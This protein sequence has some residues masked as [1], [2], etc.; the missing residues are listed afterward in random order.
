MKEKSSGGGTEQDSTR[1]RESRQEPGAGRAERCGPNTH[2]N[3]E[4]HQKTRR[5]PRQMKL[6]SHGRGNGDFLS[7]LTNGSTK[8]VDHLTQAKWV[9]I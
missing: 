9:D 2:Q 7:C 5:W 8:K 1:S 4:N 3:G 6:D